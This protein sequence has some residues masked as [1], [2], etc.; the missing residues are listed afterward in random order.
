MKDAR[1]FNHDA[2]ARND[3]KIVALIKDYGLKGYGW[4]W[5]IVENLR[6]ADNYELLDKP[7]VYKALAEQLRCDGDEASKFIKDCVEVYEL[8]HREN[9]ALMSFAL[10]ERMVRLDNIR[11]KREDAAYI[12]WEDKQKNPDVKRFIDYW[13]DKY[14][15]K[16][17]KKY[18]FQG[19][20][21]GS[22]V[23]NMLRSVDLD[24]LKQRADA[25]FN[26]TSEF[27]QEAGYTIG[28]FSSQVNKLE[29]IHEQDEFTRK[30][31]KRKKA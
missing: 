3:P 25:F 4:W 29:G 26:S 15:E 18:I 17:S 13:N 22:L 23:R 30:Y 19:G 24:D 14:L 10:K 12:R 20:K 27:I 11:S 5:V 7:Y 16:F 6:S 31:I 1:Y 2:D 28:V 21:E 8:L 9:G